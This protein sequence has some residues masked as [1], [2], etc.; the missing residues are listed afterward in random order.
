MGH[1]KSEYSKVAQQDLDDGPQSPPQRPSRSW[2]WQVSCL[3]AAFFFGSLMTISLFLSLRA[4]QANP[5]PG[6][7]PNRKLPEFRE[8]TDPNTHRPLS[9]YNGD[10]GSSPEDA[11]ARGCRYSIVLHAWLPKD[12]LTDEDVE[13]EKLMYENRVWPYQLDD[14][15]NLTMD[16]LHRGDYHHFTTHFDWH[17][18]HCMYI[19]KRVHR[20][21]LDADRKIDSYAGNIHHTSHCVKMISGDVGGM[22]NSGTKIFVKYPVC[23]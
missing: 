16:E 9:W 11:H 2:Q 17:V 1:S 19:W 18:T 20:A 22:K 7:T 15:K 4:L 21:M 10:C 5:T 8:G 13:D 6:Q 3:I 23:A 14:G 12:C